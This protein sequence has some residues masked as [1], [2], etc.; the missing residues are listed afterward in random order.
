MLERLEDC[1]QT[2][3]IFAP[4]QRP[5]PTLEPAP[6]VPSESADLSQPNPAR[7]AELV[8]W[9]AWQFSQP[10][11]AAPVDASQE[12]GSSTVIETGQSPH[13]AFFGDNPAQLPGP[14]V[15]DTFDP[16]DHLAPKPGHS[17]QPSH[18]AT[19]PGTQ[20]F[21]R[22][23]D[24]PKRTD[25]EESPQAMLEN[26]IEHLTLLAKASGGLV[27][28]PDFRAWIAPSLTEPDH[29]AI[30]FIVEG[31]EGRPL[32]VEGGYR[33]DPYD[34]AHILA[35]ARYVQAVRDAG[36]PQRIDDIGTEEQWRVRNDGQLHLI[37]LD[38]RFCT[39]S[40]ESELYNL[41]STVKR[42][43]KRHPYY[44]GLKE[45][46]DNLND[47]LGEKPRTIGRFVLNGLSRLVRPLRSS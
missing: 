12:L 44:G 20:H 13:E 15:I 30:F 41:R 19:I 39:F 47:G 23:Y 40:V 43:P 35:E 29:E 1:G 45:V 24:S 9:Y 26:Y 32:G 33:K 3:P 7:I 46:V 36:L 2:G 14:E 37:D 17:S 28:I 31:V 21:L 25:A 10:L 6:F 42:M 38:P 22:W 18:V 27:R 5:A 34:A 8:A 4:P 11:E 16:L